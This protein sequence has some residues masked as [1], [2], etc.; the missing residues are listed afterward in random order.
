METCTPYQTLTVPAGILFGMQKPEMAGGSLCYDHRGIVLRSVLSGEDVLSAPYHQLRVMKG[1]FVLSTDLLALPKRQ[2][3]GPAPHRLRIFLPASLLEKGGDEDCSGALHI[4]Q[5]HCGVM[6]N[7]FDTLHKADRE[8]LGLLEEY[9]GKEVQQDV[10]YQQHILQAI[11]RWLHHYQCGVSKN[12]LSVNA[13][14]ESTKLEIFKRVQLAKDYI[15]S[16]FESISSLEE[17]GRACSLAPSHLLKHYRSIFS[18]TPHQ[19]IV[20]MRIDYAKFLLRTT[21]W[22]VYDIMGRVGFKNASSFIRLFRTR[23]GRTPIA[24][25]CFY[26]QC[27]QK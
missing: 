16:N 7:L 9:R 20:A 15:A 27:Q 21:N 19:H 25:R 3:Y 17:I 10:P 1:Y 2:A 11:A 8:L 12:I 6:L 18:L 13:Q 14:K 4:D 24:Y 26:Q 5:L 23:T 22:P